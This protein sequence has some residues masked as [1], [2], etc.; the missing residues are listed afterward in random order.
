[1]AEAAVEVLPTPAPKPKPKPKP[2]PTAA[3][4]APR[5]A[6]AAPPLHLY[7]QPWPVP[8]W[9]FPLQAEKKLIKAA[10]MGDLTTLVR[11]VEEEVNIE[12][13]DFKVSTAQP[14]APASLCSHPP[15]AL[16]ARRPCCPTRTAGR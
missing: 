9:P 11:L 5:F 12:A 1:M 3:I 8:L 4:R 2:K 15:S 6:P 16:A 7:T 13:T 10:S 14:A